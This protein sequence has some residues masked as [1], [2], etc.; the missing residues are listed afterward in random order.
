MVISV[1]LLFIV[2]L[3]LC[4]FVV[5]VVGFVMMM[6]LVMMAMMIIIVISEMCEWSAVSTGAEPG[7]NHLRVLPA[8][9]PHLQ[10]RKDTHGVPHF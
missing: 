8:G 4:N 6:M 3:M 10:P 5:D 2:V 7:S 1:L 9:L